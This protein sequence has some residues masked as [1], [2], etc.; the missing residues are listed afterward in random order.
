MITLHIKIYQICTNIFMFRF[1][2]SQV[3][4]LFFRLPKIQ[5]SIKT[6][7]FIKERLSRWNAEV[8]GGLLHSFLLEKGCSTV[9]RSFLTIFGITNLQPS[10]E[11]LF[12]LLPVPAETGDPNTLSLPAN[13][14]TLICC[15]P[16]TWHYTLPFLCLSSQLPPCFCLSFNR[17]WTIMRIQP[18]LMHSLGRLIFIASP[19]W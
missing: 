3:F 19:A 6:N 7:C 9:P 18:C 11:K 17:Q 4:K 1:K 16:K 10:H 8:K 2:K 5:N 14:I 15:T 13:L 12:P